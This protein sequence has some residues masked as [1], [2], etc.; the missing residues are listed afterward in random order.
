MTAP[1][2]DSSR[3]ARRAEHEPEQRATPGKNSVAQTPKDVA[4]HEAASKDVTERKIASKNPDEKEDALVDES[5]ELSFPASDPP[6]V[7]GGV[8]RV[9]VPK[10]K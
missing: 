4:P 2:Q 6:A 9:D 10:E 1:Q 8:T 3:T 5:V 7:G